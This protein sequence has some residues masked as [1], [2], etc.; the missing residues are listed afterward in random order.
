MSV[1]RIFY[2]NSERDATL[3]EELAS[4]LAVLRRNG[5]IEE[6]HAQQ[7]PAGADRQRSIDEQLG[8]ADIVLLLVSPSFMASDDCHDVVKA[9][10]PAPMTG[11]RPVLIPILV[12]PTADWQSSPFG[13]LQ[14]IPRS[15]KPIT[16]WGNRDEAW[17]DVAGEIRETIGTYFKGRP[18]TAPAPVSQKPRVAAPQPP[19]PV[20]RT[21]ADRSEALR[22]LTQLNTAQLQT[23]IY[24]LE[25]DPAFL[26]PSSEALASRAIEL[27]RLVEQRQAWP[28]FWMHLEQL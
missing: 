20:P 13:E 7:V 22:R 25:V 4:H 17:A 16:S 14:A 2:C 1:V 12:R 18:A 15:G 8:K 19:E 5:V 3:R 9:I 11:R 10:A 23:L 27:L 24:L 28:K 26:L 21:G 6:F